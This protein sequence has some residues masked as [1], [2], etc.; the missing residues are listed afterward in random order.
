M[1]HLNTVKG[2]VNVPSFDMHALAMSGMSRVLALS[3]V[4]V[5]RALKM[6]KKKELKVQD[7]LSSTSRGKATIKLPKVLNKITGKESNVP[8]LFS[9]VLWSKP[10]KA[11]TKSILSKPAGYMEATIEMARATASDV[12]E[13]PVGSLDDDESDDDERAMIYECESI[14]V[15]SH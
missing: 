12:A 3:A 8:F 13:M 11:F 5:E 14:Q 10:T 7:V 9:A 1:A 2:Y 15:L 4:A 6:I